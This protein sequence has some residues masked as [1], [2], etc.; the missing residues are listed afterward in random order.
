MSVRRVIDAGMSKWLGLLFFVP[1]INFL[2]MIV[3]S[4]LPSA[5]KSSIEAT[6]VEHDEQ[7]RI[8]I[9]AFRAVSLTVLVGLAMIV[10]SV[11]GLKSYGETLFVGT[12]FIMGVLSAY[13]L[14]RPGMRG[15]GVSVLVEVPVF[16]CAGALAVGMKVPL[17]F[18]GGTN[19]YRACRNA[20][21]GHGIVDCIHSH[22]R[23]WPR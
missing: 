13:W 21:L 22:T 3:M 1:V 4:C 20:F 6:T 18:D 19:R 8:V 12:P 14:R 9:G 10:L 16:V 15:I 23:P 11:F 7:D 5:P 17:P 2:F